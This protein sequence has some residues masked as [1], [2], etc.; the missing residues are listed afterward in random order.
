MSTTTIS[1]LSDGELYT[2]AL[3]QTYPRLL[4]SDDEHVTLTSGKGIVNGILDVD[5]VETTIVA[6]SVCDHTNSA[7]VTTTSDHGNHSGIKLDKVCNLSGGQVD[8]DGIIDLDQR[9]GVSN[10]SRI[11]RNQEWDSALAQLYSLDLSKLVL[12]LLCRDAMNCEATLGVVDKA[13]V[14]AGLL[15]RDHVHEASRV[16]GIG[17]YFAIDFDQ[18]LH[19]NCLDFTRVEG[20]LETISKE[21]DER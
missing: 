8:L 4:A 14:L 5:D 20:I 16:C 19:D 2:L 3:R 1:L 11:M 13:E 6:F 7:H 21:D 15:N 9:V 17:S 12:G 10:R 18:A